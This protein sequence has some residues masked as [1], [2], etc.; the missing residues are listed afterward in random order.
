MKRDYTDGVADDVVFFIGNEVEH[1]PAFGKRT[2][3]VTGIHSTEEIALNLNG[4]EHIFFGANHSFNP[5][6]FDEETPKAVKSY[7][8]KKN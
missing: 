3:F 6:S 4:A 2:L 7:I 1:T 8:K 5:Q